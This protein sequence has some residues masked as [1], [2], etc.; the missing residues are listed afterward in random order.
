[1]SESS[2]GDVWGVRWFLAPGSLVS[3]SQL[4][5]MSRTMHKIHPKT[6]FLLLCPYITCFAKGSTGGLTLALELHGTME[7]LQL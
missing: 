6:L 2:L 5:E 7:K 4:V 3:F 1:M